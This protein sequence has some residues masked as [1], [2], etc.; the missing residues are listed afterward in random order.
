MLSDSTNLNNVKVELTVVGTRHTSFLA[1]YFTT[2]RPDW[3]PKLAYFYNTADF[4]IFIPFLSFYSIFRRYLLEDKDYCKRFLF[5]SAQNQTTRSRQGARRYKT[6]GAF[7]AE[8]V[9][10]VARRL[11]S[12]RA[13]GLVTQELTKQ[14]VEGTRLF[15]PTLVHK[16]FNGY[17]PLYQRRYL[18]M[19]HPYIRVTNPAVG[20]PVQE[21]RRA[22]FK[23]RAFQKNLLNFKRA[24]FINTLLSLTKR[25]RLSTLTQKHY[26]LLKK[27]GLNRKNRGAQQKLK[28]HL[29]PRQTSYLN[30]SDRPS[31]R[32][33]GPIYR[34]MLGRARS[35]RRAS[36]KRSRKSLNFRLK[37]RMIK[38]NWKFQFQPRRYQT[39][40][41][42]KTFSKFRGFHLGTKRNNFFVNRRVMEGFYTQDKRNR[43]RYRKRRRLSLLKRLASHNRNIYRKHKRTKRVSRVRRHVRLM[44]LT[45]LRKRGRFTKYT[46]RHRK[47]RRGDKEVYSYVRSRYRFRRNPFF[48]RLRRLRF[49]GQRV[50]RTH[51]LGNS[52]TKKFRVH[53]VKVHTKSSKFRQKSKIQTSLK[54]LRLLLSDLWSRY[55]KAHTTP[56]SPQMSSSLFTTRLLASFKGRTRY[57]M[58]MDRGFRPRS[59][60]SR[61]SRLR[62]RF[63]RRVVVTTAKLGW[64]PERLLSVDSPYSLYKV[65]KLK[66][67][68]SYWRLQLR[69]E[70]SKLAQSKIGQ[71]T[72]N[73]HTKSTKN[74]ISDRL[75]LG[76]R[77]AV[78]APQ[79]SWRE[80]SRNPLLHL[81][82]L[83]TEASILGRVGLRAWSYK[84]RSLPNFL[85]KSWF[86]RMPGLVYGSYQGK[87]L[88]WPLNTLAAQFPRLESRSSLLPNFPRL[89]RKFLQVQSSPIYGPTFR[90]LFS[91]FKATSFVGRGLLVYTVKTPSNIRFYSKHAAPFIFSLCGFLFVQTNQIYSSVRRNSSWAFAR[92][93]KHQYSFFY[94]EDIKR[95]Y[96]K[97]AGK[98]KLLASVINPLQFIDHNTL[99]KNLFRR[100]LHPITGVY[101][102]PSNGTMAASHIHQPHSGTSFVDTKL[103]LNEERYVNHLE[104]EE[105]PEPRIK[106]IRFKPGYSRI[107]RKAREAINYSLGFHFRYQHALTRRL[108]RMEEMQGNWEIKIR[109]WSLLRVVLNSHFVYDLNTSLSLI[110]SYLVY[111]NGHCSPNPRLQL[112]LGDFIQIP[113][114]LK[115]YILHRWLVNFH[116]R[117][118]LRL[119]KFTQYKNNKSRY[120]LSKQKSYHLPDWIFWAGSK[121]FDIP[122]YLEVDY[123]TLSSFIIYE[124]W[125]DCDFNP[126]VHLENRRRILRMYN[127][128][129][130][131]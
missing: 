19:F 57:R 127:W 105:A 116:A 13:E 9:P 92:I 94:K 80:V 88:H 47:V 101:S 106:R 58:M 14:L 30:T 22:S 26:P 67:L 76:S 78:L 123:F 54:G 1:H 52:L 62:K 118:Q 33:N 120:D 107:W 61:R 125:S 119:T 73:A 20:L 8:S 66:Q 110:Q 71:I 93:Q 34:L 21:A 99:Q 11:Q 130:I 70:A 75:Q 15:T 82:P 131:N 27:Y 43:G 121:S 45:L 42:A 72:K 126:L 4:F 29:I 98:L 104:T 32:L 6:R 12:D 39:C 60:N 63:P 41:S 87:Q 24:S 16:F 77:Q 122:K 10:F 103:P 90:S 35:Y 95:F 49:R 96:L 114:D 69:I 112:H 84:R 65:R 31:P 46:R 56:R 124:P 113:V 7:V 2:A 81:L 38:F 64:I 28:F 86:L 68:R 91:R 117:N 85:S 111:V 79:I 25:V 102:M 59:P 50:S 83:K 3:A 23:W 17:S 53:V 97:R 18:E 51:L 44:R 37:S 108:G 55:L 109:D 89:S 5:I 115:Y 129:Y 128:K 74:R 100:Q 40:L 48:R 36:R